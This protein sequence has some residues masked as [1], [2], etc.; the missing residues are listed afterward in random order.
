MVYALAA[1]V[2]IFILHYR[3]PAALR[4]PAWLLPAVHAA[5]GTLPAEML[6][7]WL[8]AFHNQGIQANLLCRSSPSACPSSRACVVLY[9]LVTVTT[10]QG[11]P[12]KL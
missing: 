8:V 12:S 9:N 6:S 3:V 7:V 2:G 5:A 4:T 10:A 11:S 1:A